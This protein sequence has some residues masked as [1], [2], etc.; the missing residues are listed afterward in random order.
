SL[1]RVSGTGE[2]YG[3][4]MD[5]LWRRF[6]AEHGPVVGRR[7]ALVNLRYDANARNFLV[8]NDIALSIR[9]DVVEFG[10]GDTRPGRRPRGGG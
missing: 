2:L 10:E 7:L 3:E 4:A 5:D 6:E 8:Y 9:A 1:F